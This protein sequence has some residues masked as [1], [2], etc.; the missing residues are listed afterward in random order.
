L[1]EKQISNRIKVVAKREI[2]KYGVDAQRRRTS[3]RLRFPEL[4]IDPDLAAV[5]SLC[6]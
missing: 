4:T 3:R 1:P 5:S 6:A 2:L